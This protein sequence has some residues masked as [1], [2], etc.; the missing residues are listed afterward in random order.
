MHESLSQSGYSDTRSASGTL[1]NNT[2]T[3][4]HMN[5]LT[6]KFRN[7]NGVEIKL[8]SIRGSMYFNEDFVMGKIYIGDRPYGDYPMRYN[9][10]SD[11][12]EAKKTANGE[13]EIVMKSNLLSFHIGGKKYVMKDYLNTKG[14]LTQGYL[15]V[16][17]SNDKYSLYQKKAK[18]FKQGKKAETSFH[19]PV[20]HQFMESSSFYISKGDGRP[21]HLKGSKK[22]VEHF[23][24]EENPKSIKGFV[25]KNK[26]DLKEKEGLVSLVNYLNGSDR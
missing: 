8:S 12:M 6:N 11:E 19:Q 2:T 23:F 7:Y 21:R 4:A 15:V 25:K 24:S 13:A 1:W 22:A 14:N 5:E 20:P 17:V 18:I 9:A 26:L 10:Y 3:T 16:L